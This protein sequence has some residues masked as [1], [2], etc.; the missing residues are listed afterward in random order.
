M[1]ISGG[2]HMTMHFLKLNFIINIW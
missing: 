1:H 2:L